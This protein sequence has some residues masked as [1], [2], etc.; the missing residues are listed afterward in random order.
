MTLKLDEYS[1]QI[2]TE[3]DAIRLL[4]KNPSLDLNSLNLVDTKQFNNANKLLYTGITLQTNKQLDITPQQYHKEN[5]DIWTMPDEYANIDIAEYLLNL[6]KTDAELQRVGQE[7]IMYQERN[8][9]NLLKFLHYFVT[10]LR[11]KNIVWGVGRG[12]SVSSY[13][14]FLLGV[15]KIDSLYYDLDINEFLR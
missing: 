3:D 8:M 2:H 11:E 6:C 1:R 14:L 10:I 15:H 12:S 9:F 13:V 7:L 4:L 5:S